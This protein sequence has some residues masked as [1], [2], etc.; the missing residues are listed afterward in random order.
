[1]KT[2][3]LLVLSHGGGQ[4]SAT[5]AALLQRELKHLVEGKHLIYVMSDTGDEHPETYEYVARQR[6]ICRERG[7]E[8]HFITND[9]GYHV[10]SWMGLSQAHE[11][12]IENGK[13]MIAMLNEKTCTI[14]LKLDVIYKFLDSY[15]NDRYGYGFKKEESGGC[16]K[17]AI[18]AYEAEYGKLEVII[19]FAAGEDKRVNRA[20]KME[21]KDH[22]VTYTK[23]GRKTNS[24]K[25][26]IKRLYPLFDLGMD[27]KGCQEYLA[28]NGE[29]IPMPSS[30]MRCPYM[31]P[32]ELLWLARRYPE[33]FAEWCRWEKAKMGRWASE[34]KNVGVFASKLTLSEMLA[35]AEAQYGHMTDEELNEYKFTHGKCTAAAL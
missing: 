20:K 7:I 27:R 26:V 19:G 34:E 6:E 22:A 5:N 11:R 18:K 31:P 17:E 35:K 1:M 14:N 32:Q 10:P 33:K 13:A 8:F 15:I 30:C 21:E 9:M 2:L 12:S 24:W 29:E 23:T 3:P 25:R 28:K 4:D 16:G